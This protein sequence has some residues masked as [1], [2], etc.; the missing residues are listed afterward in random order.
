VI[1]RGGEKE[2]QT[3]ADRS[4]QRQ[5]DRGRQTDRQAREQLRDKAEAVETQEQRQLRE[6]TYVLTWLDH[7]VLRRS[8]AQR[9]PRRLDITCQPFKF[10]ATV[11]SLPPHCL[12][13]REDVA[14]GLS[15]A[16]RSSEFYGSSC[17][18]YG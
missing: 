2:R 9:G 12:G 11:A 18:L 6:G 4:R 16:V 7:A 17:H 10:E 8:N 15:R 3:E 13:S 1:E 14:R 5:T